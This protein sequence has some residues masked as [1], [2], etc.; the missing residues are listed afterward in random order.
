MFKARINLLNVA[1]LNVRCVDY[2]KSTICSVVTVLPVYINL[3]PD[4]I[5]TFRLIY[6]RSQC[7]DHHN[8]DF[9]FPWSL[10][11]VRVCL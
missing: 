6:H 5:Y 9:G 8:R 3:A 10:Y 11:H 1:L 2:E 4:Q 7:E